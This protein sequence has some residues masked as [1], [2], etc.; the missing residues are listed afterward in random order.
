MTCSGFTAT[1]SK[2]REPPALPQPLRPP[3]WVL[4]LH[5]PLPTPTHLQVQDRWGLLGL[6]LAPQA[7]EVRRQ[8]APQ[9]MVVAPQGG[10]GLDGGG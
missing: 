9:Q 6:S 7:V 3:P 8:R 10:G 2:V 1:S 4:P 5:P